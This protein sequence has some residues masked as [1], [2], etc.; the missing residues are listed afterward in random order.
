MELRPELQRF[1]EAVEK[2]LQFHD[3]EKGDSWKSCSLSILG[4]RL[5]EEMDE[6][7][8]FDQLSELLD[9]AAFC[10]FLW[11]RNEIASGRMK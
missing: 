3:K 1:A 9:I 7:E 10:M 2:I 6:W 4:D 11:C 8:K 5:Q